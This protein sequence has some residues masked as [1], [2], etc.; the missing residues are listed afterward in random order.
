M[1]SWPQV[2]WFLGSEKRQRAWTG[3]QPGGKAV[4]SS[5]GE[6]V[7]DGHGRVN[8]IMLHMWGTMALEKRVPKVVH[9]IHSVSSKFGKVKVVYRDKGIHV[10][11]KCRNICIG[12]NKGTSG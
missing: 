3:P 10:L 4:G 12:A 7:F 8:L 9:I 2:G 11:A 1:R 6:A 5:C